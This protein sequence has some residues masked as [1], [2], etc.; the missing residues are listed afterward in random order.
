M[1]ELYRA[2]KLNDALST[3]NNTE[4]EFSHYA[5]VSEPSHHTDVFFNNSVQPT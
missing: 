1:N 4:N 2:Y 5:D 3:D